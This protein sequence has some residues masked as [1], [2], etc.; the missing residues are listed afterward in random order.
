MAHQRPPHI[1]VDKRRSMVRSMQAMLGIGMYA[2]GY[3]ARAQEGS[4]IVLQGLDGWLFAGWG[5]LTQ[6]DQAAITANTRL[7]AQAQQLLAQH[8]TELQVLLL[9]DKIRFYLSKLPQGKVMSEAVLQRYALISQ[10][11]QDA[12]VRT[13]DGNEVLRQVQASGQE[14]FYRTDQHWTLP[15]ADATAKA[16]AQMILSSTPQLRG[17]PGSGQKLGEISSE[18][19]FGDLAELFLPQEERRR[20]GREVFTVRRQAAA[21][22]LL[23]EAPAPVH[24]TGHSMMQPYYGFPQM[25]SHQLDRPVSLNW[26]SGN[27][28]PWVMLLEYLNSPLFKQTKPQVLVWQMFEPTYS[29]APDA[30]GFW[31]VDSLMS[32]E[33]WLSRVRTALQG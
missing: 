23:D 25:L 13:F 14:V 31:D 26:K 21:Q 12:Q 33:S 5:S 27:V 17:E 16:T 32:S 29:Y 15:A 6:V 18:R 24:I 9:P 30:S 19:R 7:I 22:G 2:A 1:D 4:S 10:A 3:G 20:L 11:L 28:G 8:G